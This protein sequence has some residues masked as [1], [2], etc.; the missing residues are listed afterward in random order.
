M[1]LYEV[2]ELQDIRETIEVDN[3]KKSIVYIEYP[4]CSD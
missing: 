3:M 2:T 4:F 1:A